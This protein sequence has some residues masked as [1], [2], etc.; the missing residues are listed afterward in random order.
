M[1]V[2]PGKEV[3][4][5]HQLDKMDLKFVDL[6]HGE[7]DIVCVMEGEYKDIDRKITEI[8][9]LPFIRKT[10]TLTAFELPLE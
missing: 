1:E 5:I 10:T 9:K 8:R 3:D 6:V 7:Y 2:A 4:I